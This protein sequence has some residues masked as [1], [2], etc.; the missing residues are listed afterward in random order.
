MG[1][2]PTPTRMDVGDG[3]RLALQ[4]LR[5][6]NPPKLPPSLALV[7]SV[8]EG[9]ASDG[10]DV[11]SGEPSPT[12]LALA[13]FARCLHVEERRGALVGATKFVTR[14][15]A[16]R[17]VPRGSASAWLVNHVLACA[18]RLLQ[19]DDSEHGEM[20]AR[21]NSALDSL[22][23][24]AYGAAALHSAAARGDADA[25]DA[26]VDLL[27]ACASRVGGDRA[28]EMLMAFAVS[29]TDDGAPD[30]DADVALAA[31]VSV[32]RGGV[33]S[34]ARRPG[35]GG[36]VAV[37]SR[38]RRAVLR[39]GSVPGASEMQLTAAV[40]QLDQATA[41][42]RSR[43]LAALALRVAATEHSERLATT[44]VATLSQAAEVLNGGSSPY[45]V[46]EERALALLDTCITA[47]SALVAAVAERGDDNLPTALEQLRALADNLVN[48][49]AVSQPLGGTLS[50]C[51]EL[52]ALLSYTPPM[53]VPEPRAD[54]RDEDQRGGQQR[55]PD[56]YEDLE[57]MED[58]EDDDE[59]DDDDDDDEDDDD[60]EDEEDE[61]EDDEDDE[62]G[63]DEDEDVEDEDD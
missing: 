59:D 45:G 42:E 43:H 8:V 24:V 33:E 5:G 29:S 46:R 20:C 1:P 14:L 51:W 32:A 3:A 50:R 47:V 10:E 21:L 9:L 36:L 13:M 22:G 26:A 63:E 16:K 25:A 31:A 62:D 60:E 17:V 15:A 28:V 55:P 48:A 39:A 58:E 53:V 19:H 56:P 6:H 23:V 44:A 35:E 7:S 49:V 54:Q 61:D 2:T 34:A 12:L 27:D 4:I 30:D 57:P 41:A 40:T 52:R 37:R 18:V 11:A 38:A